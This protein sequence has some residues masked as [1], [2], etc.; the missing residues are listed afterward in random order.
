MIDEDLIFLTSEFLSSNDI[1]ELSEQY[2]LYADNMPVAMIS[3]VGRVKS[4]RH[5]CVNYGAPLQ[6]NICEYCGTRNR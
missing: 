2:V 1:R 6:G 5:N 3:G 4:F